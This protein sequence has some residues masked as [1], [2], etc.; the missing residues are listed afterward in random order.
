[1]WER[2][3]KGE[4]LQQIAQLFDRN[5]SSIQRILSETGG[6]QPASRCRSRLALNLAEREEISRGLVCGRSI[7]SISATLERPPSTVSREIKRNGGSSNYRAG[8]ADQAAWDRAR[9]PKI[10][11]L[12]DNWNLA[13][14]VAEKLKLQWSPE[15]ISGWLKCA[16]RGNEAYQGVARDDLSHAIHSSARSAEKG[17]CRALATHPSHA[18]VATPHPENRQPWTN[19]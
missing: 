9:R 8:R 10:C 14:I 7:R 16:F 18:P 15:Q 3:R 19:S 4:S 11:K 5:H 1:M 6:I 17:T 2:W 12:A 13:H